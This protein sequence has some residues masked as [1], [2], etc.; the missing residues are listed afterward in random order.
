MERTPASAA[1]PVWE[2]VHGEP[3]AALPALSDFIALLEALERRPSV[4]LVTQP[5]RG[6]AS[7]EALEGSLGRQLWVA[8]GSAKER[9]FQAALAELEE[10]GP[11]GWLLRDQPP[12]RVGV[13]TW[14]PG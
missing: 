7:R 14:I 4:T 10:Q 13:V 6:H 12:S 3:R 9:R 1:E 5:A 11:D 2:R 8:D